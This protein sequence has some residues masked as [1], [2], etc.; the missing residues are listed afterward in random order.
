MAMEK[1]SL[2]RET[3]KGSAKGKNTIAT[4]RK[5][6]IQGNHETQAEKEQSNCPRKPGAEKG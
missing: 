1:A 6:Q 4:S 2:E 3:K 5:G